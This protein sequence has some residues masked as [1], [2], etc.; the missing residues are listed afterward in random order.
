[1]GEPARTMSRAVLLVSLLVAHTSAIFEDQA[2]LVDWH[3]ENIG[4]VRHTVFPPQTRGNKYAYV[5]TDENILAAIE[6]R[7]GATT[8]RQILPAGEA[9]DTLLAG[10]KTLFSGSS[11]ARQLRMWNTDGTLLWEHSLG[12][13]ASQSP[14][15]S[16]LTSEGV[17]SLIDGER[18]ELRSMSTGRLIWSWSNPTDGVQLMELSSLKSTLYVLG[19]DSL[20]SLFSVALHSGTGKLEHSGAVPGSKSSLSP[21]HRIHLFHQKAAYMTSNCSVLVHDLSTQKSEIR[22]LDASEDISCPVIHPVVLEDHLLIQRPSSWL[23]VHHSDLRTVHTF[24]GA[25]SFSAASDNDGHQLLS[26]VEVLK[27]EAVVS[28]YSLSPFESRSSKVCSQLSLASN[29]APMDSF[30]GTFTKTSGMTAA[31]LIV[32]TRDHSLSL[33]Q[34]GQALWQREEALARINQVEFAVP[35]TDT[36]SE[37]AQEGLVQ[38]IINKL[39]S[40]PVSNIKQDQGAQVVADKFGFRRIAVLMTDAGKVIAL[41][42]ETAQIVWSRFY[43]TEG[44]SSGQRSILRQMLMLRNTHEHAPECVVIGH[45]SSSSHFPTFLSSFNPLTGHE[46]H[47][48][49]LPYSV[50]HAI[51]LPDKVSEQRRVLLIVDDDYNAHVYPDSDEAQA[52]LA[53]RASSVFFHEIDKVKAILK[54]FKI[55]PS[56]EHSYRCQHTWQVVLPEDERIDTVSQ[57]SVEDAIFSPFHV[58]GGHTVLFKYLNP[59]LVLVSSVS[60]VAPFFKGRGAQ[61]DSGN[62]VHLYAIDAVTGHI[63]YHVAHPHSRGPTHLVIS[64]NW[65]AH[66]YWSSRHLRTELSVVE[67]WEDHGVDESTAQLITKNVKNKLIGNT[68]VSQR[69]G[70]HFVTDPS[71]P[72]SDAHSAF[73]HTAPQ[74]EEQSFVLPVNLKATG[75]TATKLGITSKHLLV[76]TSSDQLM[77]IP[78]ALINPRRP[79]QPPTEDE[80]AE[81]LM[82]YNALL[83]LINTNILSYNHTIAN[84]RGIRAAPAD[85]ESTSLVMAYGVDLFFVR[86]TP[87]KGFDVL[88]EDFNFIGMVLT[89][90]VLTVLAVVLFWCVKKSDLDFAWK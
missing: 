37:H 53:Q 29:G 41:N 74:K 90:V 75:V 60:E 43:D 84:F 46:A 88:N 70:A 89:V 25:I 42:T 11:S 31:R 78:W 19:R 2:G 48:Q 22:V 82:Q 27:H 61:P 80:Q 85:L 47:S 79:M 6:L 8:W 9:V 69:N 66:T 1:M 12:T 33:I 68:K 87:S 3:R 4:R 64:E 39:M 10:S 71:F 5:A 40:H 56:K 16:Q 7:T 20:G 35:P 51:L 18:V 73:D 26:T 34:N 38:S 13:S 52:V 14:L 62:S 57:R 49:A 45:D 58:T 65:V 21:G 77:A 81:G 50:R 28:L 36:D 17:A 23:L 55:E 86:S 15:V 30:L 44:A 67:L 54:G 32:L 76:G 83:P 63:V 59:N 24:T 72:R